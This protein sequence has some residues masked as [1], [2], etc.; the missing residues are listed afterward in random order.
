M[1]CSVSLAI[2]RVKSE[3]HIVEVEKGCSEEKEQRQTLAADWNR[4]INA[5]C[6]MTL[7][8]FAANHS[9]AYETWRREYL[10]IANRVCRCRPERQATTKIQRL[11]PFYAQ[12][13]VNEN[14]EDEGTRMRVTNQMAFLSP[15]ECWFTFGH[16][17]ASGFTQLT[18]PK[19]SCRQIAVL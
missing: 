17:E 12:D 13:R 2:H 11:G 9:I 14:N 7:R 8:Q 3:R 6:R 18:H 5:G 16:N 19:T 10:R 4:I 1:Y 15:S